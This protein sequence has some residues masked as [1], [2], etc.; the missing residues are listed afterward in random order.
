MVPQK[1][2]AFVRWLLPVV[3]GVDVD[4][5]LEAQEATTIMQNMNFPM[6]LDDP[7]LFVKAQIRFIEGGSV[8]MR[9]NVTG[10]SGV[11]SKDDAMRSLQWLLDH[12]AFH[13]S[14]MALVKCLQNS[15]MN[16]PGWT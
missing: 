7:G 2:E 14:V 10:L 1:M 3:D 11:M 13:D 8:P 9:V 12:D 5:Q 6:F 16:A 15:M 4:S